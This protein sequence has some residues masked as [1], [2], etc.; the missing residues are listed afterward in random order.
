[1]CRVQKEGGICMSL[2]QILAVIVAIFASSG[3]WTFLN[4][5]FSHGD[6]RRQ[7]EEREIEAQSKM[8]KGLG[9][10]RICSLGE[11]YLNRK[12]EPYITKDEYDNLYNYLYLPYVELGGNGTAKKIIQEVDKLPVVKGEE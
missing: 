2:E 1:M 8:L 9:H 12:P 3:F 5:R 10:D 11:Y 4:E 6:E 7:R